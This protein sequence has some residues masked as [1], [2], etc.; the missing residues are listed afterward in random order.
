[1][2]LVEWRI[3]SSH[4]SPVISNKNSD[5][6]MVYLPTFLGEILEMFKVLPFLDSR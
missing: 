5:R 6:K 1:M 2:A 4:K 3:V